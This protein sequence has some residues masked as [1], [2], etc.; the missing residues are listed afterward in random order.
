MSPVV[1]DRKGEFSTLFENLKKQGIV[2]ARI[3]EI[4]ELARQDISRSGFDLKMPAGVVLL[5][6]TAKLPKVAT[7]V[8]EFVGATARVGLPHGLGGM[9]EE[10]TGPEYAAI[11][12]LVI[13]ASGNTEEVTASG[14]EGEGFLGNISSKVK[15]IFKSLFP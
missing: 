11:Q 4:M 15:S 8:K 2:R 6:G 7:M 9:T 14:S 12:G 1:K 13:Y 3:E 10:I 5:G